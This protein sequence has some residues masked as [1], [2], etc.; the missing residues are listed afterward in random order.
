MLI[1]FFIPA[2]SWVAL[3]AVDSFCWLHSRSSWNFKNYRWSLF[4]AFE[5]GWV[6][7]WLQIALY[8][9]CFAE[10]WS[11]LLNLLSHSLL[12]WSERNW[13]DSTMFRCWRLS[14]PGRSGKTSDA[15]SKGWWVCYIGG[16]RHLS[17]KHLTLGGYRSARISHTQCLC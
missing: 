4:F 8:L 17:W 16:F 6:A 5:L 14:S 3:S 15:S 13:G 1:A 9:S 12:C 11:R 10:S 2:L 7:F